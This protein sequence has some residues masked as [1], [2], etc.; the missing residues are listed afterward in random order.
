M[1]SDKRPDVIPEEDYRQSW[2]RILLLILAVTVHNI[3]EVFFNL[4]KQFLSYL[5]FRVSPLVSDS[6]QQEKQNK[7]LLNRHSI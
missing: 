3:P 6:D 7:R 2:R 5:I 4:F 1:G